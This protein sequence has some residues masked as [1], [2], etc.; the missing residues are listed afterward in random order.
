MSAW[1]TKMKAKHSAATC[2]YALTDGSQ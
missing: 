1:T 2:K